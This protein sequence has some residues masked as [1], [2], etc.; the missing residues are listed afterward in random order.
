[1][2]TQ[3]ASFHNHGEHERVVG[4]GEFVAVLNGNEFRTRHNDYEVVMPSPA[5]SQWHATEKIPYPPVP[6]QVLA[7]RTV[8]EQ[9]SVLCLFVFSS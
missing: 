8:A 2:C 7:K 4:L 9:V 1:M 5:S 3:I 6:P